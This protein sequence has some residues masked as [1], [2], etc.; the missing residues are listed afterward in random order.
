MTVEVT[1]DAT[2]FELI[3]EG[4]MGADEEGA[5]TALGV[6]NAADFSVGTSVTANGIYTINIF[7]CDGVRF[8]LASVSGGSVSVYGKAGE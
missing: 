1:G 2:A 5:P 3:C 6:I 8:R 7:G 4:Y